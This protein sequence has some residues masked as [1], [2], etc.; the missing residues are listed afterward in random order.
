MNPARFP[1]LGVFDLT[2]TGANSGR[3]ASMPDLR[4]LVNQMLGTS[5]CSRRERPASA[6]P[7]TFPHRSALIQMTRLPPARSER[8]A[9]PST[10]SMLAASRAIASAVRVFVPSF[11]IEPT[12]S[13]N[14]FLPFTSS[15]VPA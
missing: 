10:A 13:D 15:F 9:L 7:L 12:I 6:S 8:S 5:I 11:N 1:T 14:A 4:Q 3:C 2:C